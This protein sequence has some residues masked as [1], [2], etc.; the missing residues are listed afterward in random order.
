M[1]L[2]SLFLCAAIICLIHIKLIS[3]GTTEYSEYLSIYPLDNKL[4]QIFALFQFKFEYKFA[5]DGEKNRFYGIG[6]KTEGFGEGPQIITNKF[7]PI[8]F[9]QLAAKYTFDFYDVTLTQGVWDG[10]IKDLLL[11]YVNNIP[12]VQHSIGLQIYEPGLTFFSIYIYI[13]I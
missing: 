1:N 8:P 3:A 6:D 2:K 5:T 13:Y 4:S 7:F 12:L 9:L 10:K 11:K